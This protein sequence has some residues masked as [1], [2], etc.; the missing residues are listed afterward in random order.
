[1]PA[2]FSEKPDGSF[3]I[4]LHVQPGARVTALAGLHGDA[5]RLKLAA[6]PVE[7]RANACLR[8]FLAE[9][10]AV[11]KAAVEI[12][13]GQSGRRKLVRVTGA[14]GARVAALAEAAPPRATAQRPASK[15][16]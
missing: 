3:L 13:A 14:S 10:L 7:G 9:R 16:T 15:T 2:W 6:P 5:L 1:M 12:V 11:A 8:D 4:V